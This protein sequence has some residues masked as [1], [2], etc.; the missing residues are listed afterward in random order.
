[1]NT[2]TDY[3]K[4]I[5]EEI[6]ANKDKNENTTQPDHHLFT[7]AKRLEHEII[8]HLTSIENFTQ[9]D[10]FHFN[11]LSKL[12]NICDILFEADE[13]ITPNV[14]VLLDL[15]TSIKQVI[16]DEIRPNLKLPKAFVVS[17]KSTMESSWHHEKVMME[18]QGVDERLIEIAAIP[19]MRFIEQ[20]QLLY[21]QDFTWLRGY[22]SK[23]AI[24][25]WDNADCSS[26]TEALISLLIGRDFN[27]DRFYIYCKKYIQDRTGK[28]SGKSKR[29]MEFAFCEKL[30]MEDTQVGIPSFDLRANTLSARLVKW[31]RE[32]I[33]F[34]ETHEK[35]PPYGKL[36]FY[37]ANYKIAYFFKLLSEHRVFGDTPFKELARQVS[38]TCL[39]MDGSDIPVQSII[40][41]AYPKDQPVF[42]EMETLLAKM[43]EDVRRF[44][45]KP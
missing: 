16:P 10:T 43:L 5:A 20:K 33:D 18:K 9:R 22:Q 21:W 32:E 8:H 24:M 1:M 15:L 19:F 2:E 30:V 4:R 39:S 7:E 12:V 45:R 17:Q 44:I 31:V 27:D 38:A 11:T 36:R 37:M 41:K 26:K 34:V 35:E 29:L 25:D 42:V 13:T 3:L 6:A 28:I 40:A 23:L 14:D